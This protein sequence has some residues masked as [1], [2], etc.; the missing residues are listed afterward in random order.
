MK[1]T[2]FP[3]LIFTCVLFALANITDNEINI[4]RGEKLTMEE[5]KE[6]TSCKLY[7]ETIESHI[8]LN[9]LPTA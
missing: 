5:V 6:E 9:K 1:Y 2:F 7:L 4:R 3:S 8:N